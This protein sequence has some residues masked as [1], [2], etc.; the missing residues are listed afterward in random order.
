MAD[1]ADFAARYPELV[2]CGN[3]NQQAIETLLDEF[4]TLYANPPCPKY[5]DL[6]Q[7]AYAAHGIAL[8][9]HNPDGGVDRSPG[10][11]TSETVGGVS[12]SYAVKSDPNTLRAY[13]GRTPYGLDFL[14]YVAMCL[15]SGIMVV[16]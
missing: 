3:D 15:G 8:S 9:S 2:A 14:R 11:I 7:L 5:A 4:T 12:F 13:F 16:P 6:L 1:F 10:P